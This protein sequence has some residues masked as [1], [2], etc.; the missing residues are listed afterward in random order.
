MAISRCEAA[1][2]T[3][4]ALS[5]ALLLIPI[6]FLFVFR[7]PFI[8][9]KFLLAAAVSVAVLGSALAVGDLPVLRSALDVPIAGFFSVL[10][11]SALFSV[12]GWLSWI[13]PDHSYLAA[14]P[15]IALCL[16]GF[17]AGRVAAA[18]GS[19]LLLD[20]LLVW[21]LAGAVPVSMLALGEA[22]WGMTVLGPDYD[23]ARSIASFGAPTMLA[24]YLAVVLPFAYRESFL[25][26]GRRKWFGFFVGG[27]TSAALFV[28][29]SRAAGAAAVGG[30]AVAAWFSI[31]HSEKTSQRAG[32]AALIA[33]LIG[34]GSCAFLCA[35]GTGR[36]FRHWESP[37]NSGW[38]HRF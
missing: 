10:C 18:L 35:K 19:N 27:I 34:G 2:F 22:L 20:S 25:K 24:S 32:I 16:S 4:A 14:L 31:A 38:T 11:L 37:P 12:D 36:G 7:D 28:T 17:Y 26:T 15:G 29:T 1:R 30:I 13:G 33:I 8:V 6:T 23:T 3:E 5:G 9:P 21:I